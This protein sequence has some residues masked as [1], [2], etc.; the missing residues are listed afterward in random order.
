MLR[1]LFIVSTLIFWLIVAGFWLADFLTLPKP[2]APISVIAGLAEKTYSQAEIPSHNRE[3]D[4]WIAIE[5]HV[6][7]I[8]PYLPD[9]PTEPEIIQ[10]WCGKEATQA[11]L[12]KNKARPHSPR[13]SQLLEK[14]RAGKWAE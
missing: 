9:H 8:T 12:T 1:K 6:Y 4:C 2:V 3:D 13:A 5:G 11:W 14:Y 7:D 10:P